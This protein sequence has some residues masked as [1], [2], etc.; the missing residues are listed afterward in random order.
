ME[1]LDRDNEPVLYAC[2][3]SNLSSER[4]SYYIS[5][6]IFNGH[7]YEGCRDKTLWSDSTLM[8]FPG[9]IYFG[10]S[11]PKWH[12]DGV[13]FYDPSAEGKV[14]MRLYKITWG[15]LR[16]VQK[17]EGMLDGWY[18]DCHYLGDYEYYSPCYM[19]TFEQIPIFTLTAKDLPFSNPPHDEYKEL[20]IKALYEEMLGEPGS[21]EAERLLHTS[22][23]DRSAVLTGAKL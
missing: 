14:L 12:G 15:Q 19:D 10:N 5:G 13:A 9:N 2:Y 7:P 18:D 1:N 6:G 20:I 22:Y 8:T 17:Q 16:D 23:V 4:F 11:S 21:G 3:G